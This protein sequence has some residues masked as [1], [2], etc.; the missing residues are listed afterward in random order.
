[1][2]KN[3]NIRQNLKRQQR[4][5]AVKLSIKQDVRA[6]RKACEAKNAETAAE[7]LARLTSKLDKAARKGI[8]K[9]NTAARKKSRL[10]KKINSLK[11]AS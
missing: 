7:T 9:K 2:P 3:K 5:R 11:P 8:I 6:A 4:N 10:T 1:M